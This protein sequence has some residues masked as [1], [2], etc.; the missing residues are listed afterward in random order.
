MFE[1]DL[2]NRSE[3]DWIVIVVVGYCRARLGVLY[4]ELYGLEV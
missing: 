4:Y 1:C 3:W 2:Y